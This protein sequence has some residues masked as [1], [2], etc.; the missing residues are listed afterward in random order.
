VQDLDVVTDGTSRLSVDTGPAAFPTLG[1][2][3]EASAS[4]NLATGE[5]KLFGTASNS[6]A[7][8]EGAFEEELSLFFPAGIDQVD[9]TA[10]L[11]VSGETSDNTGFAQFT[12]NSLLSMGLQNDGTGNAARLE[13]ILGATYSVMPTVDRND[14][15]C[16]GEAAPGADA[17]IIIKAVLRATVNTSSGGQGIGTFDLLNTGSIDLDV[18]D[19]TQVVSGSGV[20]LSEESA[21]IPVPAPMW[22]LGSGMAMIGLLGWRRPRAKS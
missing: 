5:I 17:C 12:G 7:S 15:G 16:R 21:V 4:V 3:A 22:L 18:P 13:N 9:L 10:S 2:S 1:G 19:G 11:S 20:F 6:L 14:F 8:A